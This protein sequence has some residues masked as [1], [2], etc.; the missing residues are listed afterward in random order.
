MFNRFVSL[1][2]IVVFLVL[3]GVV[4]TAYS[5]SRFDLPAVSTF[6]ILD[7]NG[8]VIATTDQEN[9]VPVLIDEISPNMQNAIVAIEDA[10][11]YRHRGI[12]PIGLA[13]AAYHNLKAGKIVEGGSTITQQLA[14]NLYLGP[15]RTVGRKFKE[16][17]LTIQL[18][19]RYTKE[20]ILAMYLNRIYFGQGAYGVEM[21]A[22]TYFNKSAKELDLAESAILAGIPRAPALYSPA[23]DQEAAK[24]RQGIVLRRMVELGMI[25]AAEADAAAKEKLRLAKATP[26][27][28]RAPYFVE[29]IFNYLEQKYSN[30]LEGLYAGGGTIYTTL[31]LKMQ[32]A[33]EKAL[34]E[35][36]KNTDPQ[37]EGALVALDPKTGYIKAMV[38]GRDFVRSQF[39]R[40][41]APSQPGSAFKPF[42]Y[43]AAIERG[44]T[45]GTM[46]TCE[47]VTFYQ[48]GGGKPYQPTD[49][50]GGYHNRPFTLKEALYTSDNV[51]AVRLGDQ[52]GTATVAGYARRMGID[53]PLRPYPSLPLGTSEVT[54]LEMARAYGVLAFR[55]IRTNPLYIQKMV[56]GTGRVIEEHKPVLEQVLDEKN[57][58]IV[59]DMLEAVLRPGGTASHIAGLINRPAAGKTGTTENYRDA[60]FVGYTPDLVAA[61]YVGYDDKNKKVGKPGGQIAAPVWAR[62]MEAALKNVPPAGFPVP[63]GIVKIR[64][65]ADD[66]LL[67]DDY[68][69]RTIEAAF[70]K[71]TEPVTYSSG[72]DPEEP[73]FP[74]QINNFERRDYWSKV[75][76]FIE[77]PGS[78]RSFNGRPREQKAGR[79]SD[80][81]P[82]EKS[83]D[84]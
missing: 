48:S 69:P 78:E 30:R 36:L 56:D 63:D 46:I 77:N 15:Q 8:M 71:G 34:S 21:A 67:A 27:G 19:R 25:N 41:L 39:N 28:R 65:N 33:A 47:P 22:R 2:I 32:E 59:T 79:K 68:T 42:L 31:D 58:Y 16:L 35:V 9:R 52:V 53:S 51:V 24:N 18:E 20:E 4:Y 1:I 82:D 38:G 75:R 6:Q 66:G 70:V 62:F 81:K 14:K 74:F 40:A 50:T 64:I 44:Y 37:L 55:G 72:Y 49:Y 80:Q 29:E 10:R 60:W 76:K 73:S 11:F 12:D 3:L 17:V 83:F 13:R 23:R 5:I 84:G 54:P 61:V 26:S 7:S 57:A 43:A 45:A